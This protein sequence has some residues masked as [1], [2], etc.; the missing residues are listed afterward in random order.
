MIPTLQRCLLTGSLGFGAASILVFS[1][2]AFAERW[3]YATLGLAVSYLVWTLLFILSGAAVFNTLIVGPL[4]GPRFFLTFGLA[5]LAYAAGWTG[6][7]FILRGA[8][9]E[10]CGSLAGSVL[11]ALVLAAGFRAWQSLLILCTLLFVSNSIGYFLG[12]ALNTSVGG[13]TGM[14]LWGVIYGLF[15]GAGIGAALHHVQKVRVPDADC[16]ESG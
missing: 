10:W 8:V 9:G 3:M 2:V 1:T 15:L 4:R 16:N 13:R 5:F 6:A 11:M 7:Y 14:M 12:S